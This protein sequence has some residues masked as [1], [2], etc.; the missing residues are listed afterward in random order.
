MD[1]VLSLFE[2]LLTGSTSASM[3]SS[4]FD[5]RVCPA[6]ALDWLASFI[7][8]A[9]DSRLSEATRR[10]LLQQG[11]SLYRQRGTRAG[12]I[13]LCTILAGSNV[14]IIEGFQQRRS[15]LA[16]L[17]TTIAGE[18]STVLGPG[19]QLGRDPTATAAAHAPQPWRR[20]SPPLTPSSKQRGR[21]RSTAKKKVPCPPADPP[22]PLDPDPFITFVRRYAHRF[23]VVV[24]HAYDATLADV[25][26][27][28]IEQNKPAHTVHDICWL[29]AGFR[30]GVSTYVGFGTSLG[31]VQGFTPAILGASPLGP[32][33]LLSNA[34]PGRVLGTF[35]GAAR[36]GDSTYQ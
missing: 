12:L 16:V 15:T 4:L 3:P 14:D 11:V 26:G 28:A 31:E 5:P 20:T 32:P 18:P 29:D 36:V 33:T 10:T 23:T 30:L 17:G 24:F 7:G 27:A 8:L 13:Q 34:S 22:N 19:F 9:L 1:Q 25:L 6:D 35:V 21:R 2:G